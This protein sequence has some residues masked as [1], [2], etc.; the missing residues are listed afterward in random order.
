MSVPTATTNAPLKL[1]LMDDDE[2][3]WK[4]LQNRLNPAP[5]FDLE[6]FFSA[7][8]QAGEVVEVPTAEYELHWAKTGQQGLEMLQR[9]AA[10]ARPFQL[11]LIDRSMPPGWDGMETIHR[12]QVDFPD[13]PLALVTAYPLKRMELD[14]L[15]Q[16]GV[17]LLNK[18][19][20]K[21]Q[22]KILIRLM[23]SSRQ[24]NCL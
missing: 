6:A 11:A 21:E 7:P 24:H 22:L 15:Q 16:L 8:E 3:V 2:R 23:M 10:T 12:V 19:Y 1:L 5:Q 14:V 4:I 9:D 13:L 20:E 18:P 17:E